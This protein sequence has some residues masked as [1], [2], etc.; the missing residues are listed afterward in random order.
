MINWNLGLA[1][2]VGGMFQQGFQVGQEKA[3]QLKTNNA[4]AAFAK[5]PQDGMA[6]NALID[7]DPRLG[8]QAMEQQRAQQKEREV[9]DLMQ[10]AASGDRTALTGLARVNPDLFMKMDKAVLER[11]KRATDFLGQAALDISQTPE[12]QRAAKWSAYVR[13]AEAS[14]MDIP[15]QYE[16][17]S[18]Q[19]LQGIVAEAGQAKELFDLLTPKTMAVPAGGTVYEYTPSRPSFAGA[20]QAPQAAPP[21]NGIPQ[22]VATWLNSL[23]E[24]QRIPAIAEFVRDGGQGWNTGN[25]PELANISRQAV[26]AIAKGANPRD[27]YSRI[28]QMIGGR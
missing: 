23:P 19:A 25:N 12:E 15:T 21:V 8:M 3:R 10:R 28:A 2:D 7:A 17:Y 20:P 5:N 18:P 13:Q 11:S 16:T 24:E 6:V 9:Q 22:D 27:V 26:E 1:P 14:G 4:L